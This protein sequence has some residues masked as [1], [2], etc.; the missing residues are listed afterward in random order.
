MNMYKTQFGYSSSN[1]EI[2]VVIA[3]EHYVTDVSS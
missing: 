3:P 2:T 1:I